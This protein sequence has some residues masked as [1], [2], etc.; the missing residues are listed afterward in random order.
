MV[1]VI[2]ISNLVL[3]AFLQLFHQ[4]HLTRTIW[5]GTLYRKLSNV[6]KPGLVIWGWVAQYQHSLGPL[7]RAWNFQTWHL[8]KIATF[9]ADLAWLHFVIHE[10]WTCTNC[11]MLIWKLRWFATLVPTPKLAMWLC[12]CVSSAAGCP[13]YLT[14]FAKSILGQ[15][16]L[17]DITNAAVLWMTSTGHFWDPCKLLGAFCGTSMELLSMYPLSM[18][19]TINIKKV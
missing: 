14:G 3:R 19:V 6:C 16:S 10:L 5:S 15:P 17:N 13:T 11:Q 7:L 18:T 12:E 8:W 2:G 1:K 9:L 4:W